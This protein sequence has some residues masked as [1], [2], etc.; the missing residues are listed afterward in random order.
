MTKRSGKGWILASRHLTLESANNRIKELMPRGYETAMNK[1]TQIFKTKQ[2]T[3][4]TKEI[5]KVWARDKVTIGRY[6]PDGRRRW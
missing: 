3:K 4:I 1:T 6:K 5:Y 2:N